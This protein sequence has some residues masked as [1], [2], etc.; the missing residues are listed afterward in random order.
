MRHKIKSL[1]ERLAAIEQREGI[2]G[3]ELARR[4]GMKTSDYHNKLKK[5]RRPPTTAWRIAL[6]AIDEYGSGWIN[7]TAQR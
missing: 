5:N 7:P 4:L 2:S 6:Q 3:S 1:S